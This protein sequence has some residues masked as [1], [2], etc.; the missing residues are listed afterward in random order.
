MEQ[1]GDT[2]CIILSEISQ[3]KKDKYCVYYMRYI[4]SKAKQRNK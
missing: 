2:E 4:K 3:I 1:H